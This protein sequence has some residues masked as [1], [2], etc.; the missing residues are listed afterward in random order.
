M[1]V[2]LKK[3]SGAFNDGYA[4]DKHSMLSNFIGY[5]RHGFRQ[6]K[7]MRTPAGEAMYLFK[8]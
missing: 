1:K 4:L 3:I 8:Y 6:Y 5:N 2:S 7:T